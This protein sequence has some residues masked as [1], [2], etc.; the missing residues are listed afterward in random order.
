MPRR[1]GVMGAQTIS[2]DIV[3]AFNE[4][5]ANTLHLSQ[6]YE[7]VRELRENRG[8]DIGEYYLLQSYIRWTLQNNSRSRG[9]DI[10]LMVEKGSGRWSL[11]TTRK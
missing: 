3:S 1:R 5:G 8:E 7:K 4:I 2:D 6:I 11:K 9:K 10:F